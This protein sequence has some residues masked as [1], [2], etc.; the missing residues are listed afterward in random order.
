MD[1]IIKST[2]VLSNVKQLL[3]LRNTDNDIWINSL[4]ETGARDLNSPETL[5]I[6]HCEIEVC[7]NRFYMPDDCKTLLAFR[8]RGLNCIQGLFVDVDFFSQCGCNGNGFGW[9][10]SIRSVAT[11]NGRWVTFINNWFPHSQTPDTFMYPNQDQNLIE[12]AYKAVWTDEDGDIVINEE[13][14]THLSFYA[15]FWFANSYRENYTADQIR[16]WEKYSSL[17]GN[18]VRSAAA[19]R[20]FL[21][22]R[23]QITN[24]MY[25][26]VQGGGLNNLSGVFAPFYASQFNSLPPSN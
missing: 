21:Q 10:G 26:V 22:Q 3:R 5:I 12:I 4:I 23:A 11:I 19:R 18:R 16:T 15:A 6:K 24:L 1:A 25:T 8:G 14:Y 2:D 13:A 7:D 9:N 17:Q 20:K